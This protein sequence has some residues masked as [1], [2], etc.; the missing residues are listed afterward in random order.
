M[1]SALTEDA[2]I[3]TVL[4]L[5]PGHTPP[6][7]AGDDAAVLTTTPWPRVITTDVLIEGTHFVRAH[8]A[9]AL[10][11]KALAVNLSDVAAMGAAPEAFLLSAALPADVPGRWW[12]AFCR[13]LGACARDAGVYVAGG[14]TVKSPGPVSLSITAWGSGARLLHRDAGRPG[15]L[16]FVAGVIGRSGLG[17]ERWL[18][19]VFGGA[20]DWGPD[21]VAGSDATDP[22]LLHHLRPTPPLWAGPVAAE[23]GAHAAMD[24][25]DGLV[26]DLPRLAR[27]SRLTLVVDLDQ[28]PADPALNG[29]SPAQR[30]ATGEDYGLVVLAP[31]SCRAGLVARGFTAI[32][33]A[34]GGPDRGHGV[35]WRVG[36]VEQPAPA[37]S[38]AHFET[39][40]ARK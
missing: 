12:E 37:P 8:P 3:E 11:Y 35:I 5:V 18:G 4:A 27:A 2:L 21:L 39:A 16:I 7:G 38:F 9:E 10:G 20:S 28:L 33:R 24:L 6:H 32:G 26:V 30:A 15:D 29:L 13:G 31:P 1:S 19:A 25:S 40:E 34:D 17:L 36:G 14:D 23:L 22:C